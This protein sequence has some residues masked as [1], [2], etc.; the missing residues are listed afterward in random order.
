MIATAVTA[1]RP[2]GGHPLWH[3]LVVA[4]GAVGVFVW[5]KAREWY[6][7]R[8]RDR[9]AAVRQ[10]DTAHA[11]PTSALSRTAVL[12]LAT[13]SLTTGLIHASVSNE[14]FR[15]AFI[16]GLFF[17]VA[18]AAQVAWAVLLFYR[19]SR[20]LL[21]LGATGNAAVIALW[22]VTRTIGLPIGPT[23]WHP[24]PIGAR[25]LVSTVGELAIVAGTVMLLTRNTSH[26][27]TPQHE[28]PTTNIRA[29]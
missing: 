24:E 28:T 1:T 12:A 23:P 16:F 7:P 4:G 20:T 10:A 18:S 8:R 6:E 26:A 11:R 3:L 21:T 25:D 17:V 14:H 27:T 2:T 22:T 29:A 5:I 13:A 15:E 19:P 9:T